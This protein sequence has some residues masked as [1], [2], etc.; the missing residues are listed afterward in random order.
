MLQSRTNIL[1]QFAGLKWGS[2]RTLGK[3]LRAKRDRVVGGL[4]LVS[5]NTNN[6]CIYSVILKGN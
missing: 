4:K 1:E 2:P 5:Q 3:K 6:G